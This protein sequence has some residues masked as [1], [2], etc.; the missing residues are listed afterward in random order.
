MIQTACYLAFFQQIGPME[1]V[2]IG[3][4]L[5]LLFGGRLP[6]M[7]KSLGRGVREFKKGIRDIGDDIETAGED[8]RA[9]GKGGDGSD[10]GSGKIGGTGGQSLS[11]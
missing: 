7:A 5:L 11:G 2:V 8:K 9:T 6:E 4:I 10:T 3:A 1:I